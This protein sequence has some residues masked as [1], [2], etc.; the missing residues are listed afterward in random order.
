MVSFL[1]AETVTAPVTSDYSEWKEYFSVFQVL[2]FQHNVFTKRKE[3]LTK[4]KNRKKKPPHNDMMIQTKLI[5][6][7]RLCQWKRS[8]GICLDIHP[9]NIPRLEPRN[10]WDK[11]ICITPRNTGQISRN[12]DFPFRWY[13]PIFKNCNR[14]VKI[15]FVNTMHSLHSQSCQARC[16]C[17]L[18]FLVDTQSIMKKFRLN[19]RLC[20]F[21][22]RFF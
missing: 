11:T 16:H 9:E 3:I 1:S 12:S 19:C 5:N 10:P 21:F 13:P 7:S 15:Q 2:V 6:I 20:V 18:S 4:Q 14:R 8:V 22:Y 17:S